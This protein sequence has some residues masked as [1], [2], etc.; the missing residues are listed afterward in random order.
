MSNPSSFSN[1][2]RSRSD[3]KGRLMNSFVFRRKMYCGNKIDYLW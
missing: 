2:E 1:T 3:F